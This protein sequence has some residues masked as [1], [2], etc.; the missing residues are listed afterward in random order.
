MAKVNYSDITKVDVVCDT[1]VHHVALDVTHLK[2]LL[3]PRLKQ[4][5][6]ITCASLRVLFLY[7]AVKRSISLGNSDLLLP[8][9]W[10]R[11]IER[12]LVSKVPTFEIDEY[13]KYLT[14]Q[15]YSKQPIGKEGYKD[16]NVQIININGSNRYI[17]SY[18]VRKNKRP[19]P[20][21]AG[22]RY[23]RLVNQVV[24]WFK[25]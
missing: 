20:A 23:D 13:L 3:Q 22:S 18:P 19:D 2:V 11:Y 24:K 21:K 9:D 1:A 8:K 5:E 6:N 16:I 12:D 17:L 10:Y 4:T 25:K 14:T 15:T 7:A